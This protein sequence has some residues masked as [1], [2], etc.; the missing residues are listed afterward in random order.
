VNIRQDAPQNLA[1]QPDHIRDAIILC[2]DEEARDAIAHW[3]ATLSARAT[4]AD[5]GYHASRLLQ[6]GAYGLLITDRLLPPW[7]G[8][9]TFR[10]LRDRNPNLRIMFLDSGSVDDRILARITGATDLLPR[11][12]TRDGLINAVAGN[13]SA[14]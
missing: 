5:D 14:A 9:E 6:D 7:P 1:Q 13:G 11:P 10:A 2:F 12:L 4:V 8:L 3:Y